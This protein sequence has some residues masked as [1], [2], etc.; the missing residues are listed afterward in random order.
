MCD[1]N[2]HT[3]VTHKTT[4]TQPATGKKVETSF[5][6]GL[7]AA[8]VSSSIAMGLSTQAQAETEKAELQQEQQPEQ[9]K[10]V[11][12]EEVTVTARRREENA[13]D[14]P[15]AIKVMDAEFLEKQNI[16]ELESLATAVPAVTI[17]N[18]GTSSNA[19]IV[20]V[21]GQRPTDTTLSL[22]QSIPIYFNEVVM[23]PSQGTNLSFYDLSNIQVLKGPQG[24]LF[25][26]NTTGGALL[27]TP[28]RPTTEQEGYVQVK[29][30]TFN[31]AGIEGAVNLPVNENIQFR[32][33]GRALKRDGYQ[34]VVADNALNGQDLW[35][36]DSKGLRVG[37]NW[38]TDTFSN[39]ATI[40][41]DENDMISRAPVISGYAPIQ[42]GGLIESAY[43]QNGEMD[44]LLARQANR[45]A[46]DVEIDL[47]GRETVENL[48]F[49]N[50]TEFDLSDSLTIKNIFGYREVETT[51]TVDAD[52]TPFPIFSNGLASQTEPVTLNP[53]GKEI[54]EA[55]QFSNELQLIG[56]TDNI[57]WIAGAFWYQ[58]DASQEGITQV[59]S[60]DVTFDPPAPPIPIPALIYQASP[61]GDVNN[62]AYGLFGEATYHFNDEWATTVGLR[63]SWDKRSV[64]VKN[65]KQDP[66]PPMSFPPVNTVNDPLECAV[67]DENGN[68]AENCERTESE[69]FSSPTGRVSINYTPDDNTLIYGS[70]STGYRSGGFN[71]RAVD[72]ETLKP[73]DE[74][75]VVTY[76]VGHKAEWGSVRTS[77]A[78]YIQKYDDIQKTVALFSGTSFET[79]TINAAS[80]TIQGLELDV[81]WAVNHDLVLTLGYALTDA[82]YDKWIADV[83]VPQTANTV[84]VDAS[85]DDFGFTP[86]HTA[87][88]SAA[89]TL[90][91]PVSLGEMTLSGSIY[92]QDDMVN[93]A[94]PSQFEITVTDDNLRAVAYDSIH[95]KS[96]S[97]SNLR[98][99]WRNMMNS[100][101][102]SAL[103]VSNVTDK[104]YVIGGFNQIDSLGLVESAYAPP[105]TVVASLQ[106]NF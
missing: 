36:E 31:L 83:Q 35:D 25:G 105:R 51:R 61:N 78:A 9:K 102:D 88:L 58:M 91:T 16:V 65:L 8:A 104:E 71:L 97:V 95:V 100:Q 28:A 33:A 48:F 49:S 52:G 37:M 96:Y 39:L 7:I 27:I 2:N 46:H 50:I 74:E 93:F 67:K 11:V 72:N 15:I 4:P 89:Y 47:L 70:V 64:T 5:K 69:T 68:E 22:D 23:T 3:V 98:F 99:D 34:E 75:T 17:S 66:P 103:S 26:R 13:Q 10:A 86:E 56:S 14:V 76:E 81:M 60:G 20:A 12:L 29:A 55:E 21:R 1:A 84:P 94:I 82:S 106:Y 79:S 92:W 43:N 57:E 59:F 42:L 18:T 101:F 87:T 44:A 53:E 41:Y 6:L 38:D 19:P 85:G 73:F 45:S 80:A 24:T 62:E 30:G 63:Q 77:I 54:I 90:P 32:I 40:A